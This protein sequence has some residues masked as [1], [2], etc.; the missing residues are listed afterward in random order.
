MEIA[1]SKLFDTST[2][3]ISIYA[4]NYF[5]NNKPIDAFVYLVWIYETSYI[6]SNCHL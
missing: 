4:S 1:P 3:F 2:N 5:I 6:N